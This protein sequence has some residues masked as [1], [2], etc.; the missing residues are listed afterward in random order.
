MIEETIEVEIEVELDPEPPLGRRL[1]AEFIGTTLFVAVGTGAATV[2]LLG[3]LK[4][5]AAAFAKI[6]DIFGANGD[7][8]AI[9]LYSSLHI[10][11]GGDVVPVALAFAFTLAFLVYALGGISGAHFNPA[12]TF[13]LAVSRRFPW[14]EVPLYWV[15]QCVGGVL[16][17]LVI[18]GIY[19]QDGASFGGTD[20]LFGGTTVSVELWNGILAEALITFVL[21]TAI[22]AI[23]VD[24]RAPKGWSGL[25]IGLALAGGILA[26]AGATGG[27]ANFARSLGP[28][29][30]AWL[31]LADYNVS[32]IPW[33]DLIVYAVGPLLGGAAAALVYETVTGLEAVSPAPHPGAATGGVD[34][35]LGEDRIDV[36]HDHPHDPPPPPAL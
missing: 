21:V 28:F 17:A 2:M 18:A 16:G 29:V 27:S 24:P 32:V 26:T 19:G 4:A 7:P 33:S 5:G 8:N 36:H 6:S 3:P 15:V 30:T 12:V 31:P 10:D 11:S 22:M 25:V 35:V 13:A 34:S 20:I 14:R 9:R 1:L 23:A